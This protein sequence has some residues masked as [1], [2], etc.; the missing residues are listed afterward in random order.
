[1]KLSSK[2]FYKNH[3]NEIGKFVDKELRTL[4]LTN[5]EISYPG[6]K[7]IG[8]NFPIDPS[9]FNIKNF[10]SLDEN[11]YDLIIISDVF[12]LHDDVLGLVKELSK[13]LKNNGK[14]LFSNLN[15]VWYFILKFL[16]FIKLKKFSPPRN[17]ISYK[18]IMNVAEGAG[19]E[20][21]KSYTRLYFPFKLFGMGT[22]T[23]NLLEILFN[24]FN[25]G[26]KSYSIF[27]KKNSSVIS[28]TKS[29]IIPAK[30]EE[31]NIINLFERI[32]NVDE[33]Y[34]LIFVIGESEDNSYFEA[35][36]ILKNNPKLDIS[37]IK[38]N[39]NGKGN[40]VFEGLNFV[41]NDLVAILD[42]DLSVDPEVLPEAFKII[43]SGYADF[44][45]C[46]RMIYRKEAGSM[47]ILNKIANYIFPKLVNFLLGTYLT[48]TL[49]GTKIFKKQHLP[50]LIKWSEMCGKSDPYGDFDML[51]S[52]SYY[53][54]KISEF[55]VY[56]KSRSYGQSQ[57]NRFRGGY[58]LFK[59]LFIA[60]KNLN[61]SK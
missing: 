2:I 22:F 24:R 14:I 53:N 60:Y 47:R 35:E 45:N 37:L 54:E 55:P 23:N 56:Y 39:S 25:M 8:E 28:L 41:R 50:N 57:I 13:K 18:K 58:V 21:I 16:E 52:A 4:H 5:R 26:I 40:G 15:S 49:C 46:T 9:N 59:Y 33:S 44:V 6:L 36:K 3:I 61:V 32:K 19:L 12:E 7:N 38:Q 29:I 27:R 42:S 20:L 11:Y 1:M 51:F 34:Q 10:K 48:D 17:N 43:E 31:K 30:N